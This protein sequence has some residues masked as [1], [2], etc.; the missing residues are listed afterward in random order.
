MKLIVDE[1]LRPLP[2]GT[3]RPDE[4]PFAVRFGRAVRRA[5]VIEPP[6]RIPSLSA[7]NHPAV[8]QAEKEGM[9]TILAR[10][11]IRPLRTLPRDELALV[12]ENQRPGLDICELENAAARYHDRIVKFLGEARG[13]RVTI[14]SIHADGV[15]RRTAVKRMN[16]L[17][18]DGQLFQPADLCSTRAKA[19]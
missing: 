3:N 13:Q 5:A 11:C 6:R 18:L 19:R 17:P 4:Y 7:V 14:G 15:E 10:T 8:V 16:L 1:M 9:A 12:F 2:D